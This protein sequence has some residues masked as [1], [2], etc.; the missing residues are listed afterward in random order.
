MSLN[1]RT[2]LGSI[3]LAATLQL[4]ILTGPLAHTQG[5]ENN[6]ATDSDGKTDP[7]ENPAG[8]TAEAD[9]PPD[10]IPAI[11][12]D[13]AVPPP[14]LTV[15][16]QGTSV[17][18]GE[19]SDA[20]SLDLLGRVIVTVS[21]SNRTAE[22]DPNG[23]FR[24]TGLPPGDHTLE[25]FKLGYFDELRTVTTIAN[26][27]VD[28][29]ISLR[30][31]PTGE[32][33]DEFTM[34]EEV[35][36]G[37]YEESSNGDL[38]LDLQ[39]GS[40]LVSG[41]SKEQFSQAGI[42]DAAGAVSKIAGANIV[43]GKYAVVRG[44][45]DR[46]SNTLVN[47]TQI[48]SADPSKKAVQLDL[49]P[50]DLLQSV[51]IYKNFTPDLPAEFAGGTVA[52]QTLRFP[53]QRLVEFSV[54]TTWNEN[55]SGSEM[56]TIRGRNFGFWGNTGDKFSS[57]AGDTLT[58]LT[59]GYNGTRPLEFATPEE[60]K[61]AQ[62]AAAAF[63]EIH[64]SAPMR[65]GRRDPNAGLE[66]SLT[67]GETFKPLGNV[68]LGTVFAFTW[69]QKD[70]IRKGV[71]TG[72]LFNP[73][74]DGIPLTMDDRLDRSGFED[75][76]T[77][78]LNWGMLGSIGAKI[79]ENHE[80]GFTWF[81]NSNSEDQVTIGDRQRRQDGD[82][83]EYLPSSRTPGGAGAYSYLGFENLVPLNRDLE[84]FQLDGRH[85]FGK[86]DGIKLDWA[87]SRSDS[88][89]DRPQSRALFNYQLDYTDPR[90][91]DLQNDI[92]LPELGV[93]ETA[94]D[95]PAATQGTGT[96]QS[97]R[98]TL[99]TAETADNARLD[100]TF[101]LLNRG[102]DQKLDLKLGGN[103]FARE[104]EVRGRFFTYDIPTA[105]NNLLIGNG[106]LVGV[107]YLENYDSKAGVDGNDKFQGW[108]GTGG[109]TGSTGLI[110]SEA[111]RSGRTVR[112][113]DAGSEVNSAY[114]MATYQHGPWNL[115]AGARL[116]DES[117]YYHVLPGLNNAA[118]TTEEPVEQGEE[119]ILPGFT[120]GRTFGANDQ[121]TTNFAA[122]RTIAR[123]TFYEF[124]PVQTEDQATG[125]VIVGNP[126]LVDTSIDN[127]DLR[128]GWQPAP[129]SSLAIG[130][131]YK[132]M[133]NP[134]AQAYDLTRKTWVNG[135]S[136]ELKGIEIEARHHFTENWSLSSNY[137]YIDSIL[138][139]D[140]IVGTSGTQ[141]ISSSYEGQPENIFNLILGYDH[142]DSGYSAS[143]VYN[144]TDS[145][146]TGVPLTSNSPA[147]VRESFDSL[148]LVISR[149]FEVR[150]C[151]GIVKLKVVN[152]LDATDTESFD[153]TGFT[154]RSFKPGRSYTLSYE[155]EF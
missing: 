130:L 65:S 97:F 106:G 50:S 17:I 101:P 18:T 42:S 32:G 58:G 24:I 120:L 48:S 59:L 64:K 6:I 146:L 141:T 100:L 80:I 77:S 73:G 121:F 82:N 36:V 56:R 145:Y 91:R 95:V 94:A 54:G 38:F 72:R 71:E 61:A 131:F 9:S 113:V 33:A 150:D 5:I 81:R 93:L 123:P 124:A 23:R 8:T 39:L 44:L 126:N 45:G 144:F 98:E 111:T 105:L 147:I 153:G 115:L 104:R 20:T 7:T 19:V 155:M 66:L 70:S 60:Q 99:S 51:A 84:L 116:E 35:V 90:I 29:R 122:S 137:T 4:L 1:H 3:A 151:V 136:G 76:Y 110:I 108:T 40:N 13:P 79:G 114:L 53:E 96:L 47:G 74:D 26:Q 118:F 152:L 92:Y 129:Q 86:D 135:E 127:F 138:E 102:E 125:D 133:K 37:E 57:A 55:L 12:P 119:N 46:Y 140:Q 10:A 15:L 89:E 128:L 11:A 112:N 154:Y 83:L 63:A 103:H 27:P 41:I 107:D 142:P 117:R 16:A 88:L 132:D 22:T 109:A 31:K 143:L 87:L 34:D 14:E 78:S 49:F 85:T 75:Q 62:D 21:G 25:V 67:L 43:G 134:I 28:L 139:Y 148:D 52:I 30:A 69:E 149:R 2:S 68:E